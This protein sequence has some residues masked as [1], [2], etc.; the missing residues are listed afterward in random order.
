[1]TGISSD[2][3]AG[4]DVVCGVAPAGEGAGAVCSR[5]GS[6]TEERHRRCTS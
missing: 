3:G 4:V 5:G 2:G 1:M 6:G